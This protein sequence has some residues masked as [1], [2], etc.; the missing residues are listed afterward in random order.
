MLIA[1]ILRTDQGR[2]QAWRPD[3][4]LTRKIRA[5]V[6]YTRFLTI[7]IVR[8][9]NRQRAVLNRYYPAA[10]D[11]FSNLNTLIAQR[12]IQA[13][14]TPEEA[15]NLELRGFQTFA[16]QNRYHHKQNL[17]GKLA[18]LRQPYPEADP[19]IVEACEQE[20]SSLATLLLEMLKLKRS[21]LKELQ[22]LLERHPDREIYASLPGTGVY[23]QSALLS[24]FGDDRQRFSSASR[25]QV[26]AGTCP[27][28]ISSGKRKRVQF[29][30]ACNHDFRH[31]VQQWA[32]LSLRS[33]VW[34][35]VY[36]QRV[37]PGCHSESHAFRCLGNRWLA[38]LW[39]LWQDHACYDEAY[40][41]QQRAAKSQPLVN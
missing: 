15:A 3:S 32:K 40:H 37:R 21:N 41:F 8:L 10:V 36:Y 38:I 25:V 39:R 14:P 31:V 11:L 7:N 18:S 35:N 19:Q 24:N 23:L 22:K 12:F 33:S 20:A 28:T 29:R 27:V 4:E 34:A 16:K 5:R 17:P 13:F 26:L 6:N 30:K 2:L 9:S 1:D